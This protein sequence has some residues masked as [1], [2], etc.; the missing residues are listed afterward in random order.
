[1]ELLLEETLFDETDSLK[2]IIIETEQIK[3]KEV[4]A[5]L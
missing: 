2:I 3:S 1:M 4:A 5:I